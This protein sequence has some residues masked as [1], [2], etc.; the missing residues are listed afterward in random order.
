MNRRTNSALL[1]AAMLP[2]TPRTIFTGRIL[3][4]V[5]RFRGGFFALRRQESPLGAEVPTDQVVRKL[6]CGHPGRFGRTGL[7]LRP[8]APHELLG[9]PSQENHHTKFAV[10]ALGQTLYHWS[11]PSKETAYESSQPDPEGAPDEA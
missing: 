3:F 7:G 4:G 10:D 6:L 8:G 9:S 11:T 1:Y 2:E 5:L